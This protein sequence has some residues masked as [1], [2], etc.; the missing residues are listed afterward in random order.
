MGRLL[1]S[2]MNLTACCSEESRCGTKASCVYLFFTTDKFS[3]LNAFDL[4][5]LQAFIKDMLF[6]R[7]WFEVWFIKSDFLSIR[8]SFKSWMMTDRLTASRLV[9]KY[10]GRRLQKFD[11]GS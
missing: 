11:L 4:C 7:Y 5:F 3:L 10:S 6:V 9:E 2:L 1:L 8:K